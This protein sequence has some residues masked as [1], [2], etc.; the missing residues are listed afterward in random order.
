M[1]SSLC[2]VFLKEG[3]FFICRHN[4]GYSSGVGVLWI[5]RN[6]ETVQCFTEIVH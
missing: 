1:Y 5:L 2:R 4:M 6:D 3:S